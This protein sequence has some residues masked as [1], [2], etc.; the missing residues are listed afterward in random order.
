MFCRILEQ[1]NK[2]ES[3]QEKEAKMAKEDWKVTAILKQLERNS[4]LWGINCTDPEWTRECALYGWKAMNVYFPKNFTVH[5]DLFSLKKYLDLNRQRSICQK[6]ANFPAI[7]PLWKAAIFYP[8]G[9]MWVSNS[10][11]QALWV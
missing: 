7:S 9:T 4:Q 5:E 11:I 8:V 6:S 1:F 2:I 10:P 3:K